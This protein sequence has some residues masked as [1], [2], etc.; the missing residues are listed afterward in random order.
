[1]RMTDIKDLIQ[2]DRGQNATTIHLVNKGGFEDFAKT[3]SAG[4]RAQLAA[5]KFDGSVFQTAIVGDGDGFFAVGGVG[6]P[7]KLKTW[8]LAALAEL[9]VSTF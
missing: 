2:P 1:M 5:Q 6:N 3:L 4:Q 7:E 9:S 8:S